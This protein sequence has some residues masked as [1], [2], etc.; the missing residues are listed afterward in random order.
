[1]ISSFYLKKI[2]ADDI[3]LFSKIFFDAC[4]MDEKKVVKESILKKF[5]EEEYNHLIQIIH[6]PSLDT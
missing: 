4:S 3:T 5:S 1:M 6:L 2:S